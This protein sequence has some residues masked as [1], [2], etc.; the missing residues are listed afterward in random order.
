[1]RPG[2]TKGVLFGLPIS[3]ALWVVIAF[4]AWRLFA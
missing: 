1:M 2:L 3:L 4:V